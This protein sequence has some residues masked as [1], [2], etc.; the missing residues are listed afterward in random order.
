[1]GKRLSSSFHLPPSRSTEQILKRPAR[2]M[3]PL[4]VARGSVVSGLGALTIL[5]RAAHL[6][7]SI[8]PLRRLWHDVLAGAADGRTPES[9]SSDETMRR[10]LEDGELREQLIENLKTYPPLLQGIAIARAVASQEGALDRVAAVLD[11]FG[12]YAGPELQE[13]IRSYEAI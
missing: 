11:R 6:P 12:A 2:W 7:R 13:T 9:E 4:S 3:A 8:A 5:L 10:L 1:M